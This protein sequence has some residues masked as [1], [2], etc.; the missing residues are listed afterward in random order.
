MECCLCELAAIEAALH[1][2]NPD[3]LG[4][5]LAYADWHSELQIL[6]PEK[7]GKRAESSESNRKIGR[8]NIAA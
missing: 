4:L 2:S 7:D 8:G 6:E 5:L 1:A 3:I